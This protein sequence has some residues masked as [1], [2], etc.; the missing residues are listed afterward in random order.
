MLEPFHPTIHRAYLLRFWTEF[1]P[2]SSR[3]V[4]RFSLESVREGQMHG[5][6]SLEALVKFIHS[7][8]G[9]I[10]LKENQP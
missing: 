2:A 4:W 5:F 3:L 1:S 9:D 6:S 10:E 7:E 8:I